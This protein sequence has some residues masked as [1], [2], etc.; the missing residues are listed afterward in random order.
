L[1]IGALAELTVVPQEAGILAEE[2]SY[3]YPP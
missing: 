3:S 2:S 1:I